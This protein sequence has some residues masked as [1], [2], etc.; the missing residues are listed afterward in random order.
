[1]TKQSS[2]SDVD[3]VVIGGGPAGATAAALLASWGRSVVVVHRETAT[4]SLA[5][6]LPASTRKLLR[7]LGLL[8]LVDA[9]G[10]HPNHGNISRWAGKEAVAATDVAG[11]HVSRA[12]FDRLLRDHARNQGAIVIEG[13]ARRVEL[14][15]PVTVECVGSMRQ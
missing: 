1:M 5:E 10:F 3:V 15:N 2:D 11:Y 13:R 6:S 4:P 12:K 9:S 14:A 7:F 8:E